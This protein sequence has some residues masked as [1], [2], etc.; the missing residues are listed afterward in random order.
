LKARAVNAEP[1]S[2]PSVSVPGA[3]P[4]SVA[5]RSI[6]AIASRARQRVSRCQPTISRVQQTG[7]GHQVDPAGFGDP[8]AR[9]VQVPE[10]IGPLDAEE[11][12][13][14]AP[15]QRGPAL[16][17]PPLTHHA[18]HPLAVHPPAQ[19]PAHPRRDQAVAVGR[20]GLGLGDDRRLDRVGR[21]P[22]RRRRRSPR[23]RD[24]VDRRAADL[25]DARHHRGPVAL[26]D[27]LAGVGDALAHSHALKPF[28]RIS[29]S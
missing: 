6:S 28:P 2:V 11:P 7:R 9:H 3:M 12:R 10:L 20:V 25:Q 15:L 14:P 21:R 13:P 26:G 5:A 27:Q 16:D 24:A 17:Q 22:A 29:A 8:D 1:L 4:R 19:P 18:Q 23:L